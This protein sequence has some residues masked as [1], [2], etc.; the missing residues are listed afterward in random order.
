MVRALGLSLLL[1]AA[2][3]NISRRTNDDAGPRDG[4]MADATD[5]PMSDMQMVDAMTDAAIDA[6]PVP[7]QSRELLN[8]AG[9]MNGA[10]YKFE[11]QIGNPINQKPSNGATHTFEGNA[12]VKP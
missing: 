11:V 7:P 10:T 12:T 5:A 2:C 9:V 4:S 8:G 1:T 6:P 3:G